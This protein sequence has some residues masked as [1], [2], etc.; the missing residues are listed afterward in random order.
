[1]VMRGVHYSADSLLHLGE[2][3]RRASP[4]SWAV[5][6]IAAAWPELSQS[7]IEAWP[8]GQ[9]DNAL[10]ALRQQQFGT[11]WLSEPVCSA[12]NATFEVGFD[13]LAMGFAIPLEWQPD[14]LPT[15]E[16]DFGAVTISLRPL[17]VHDLLAIERCS[18]EAGAKTYLK[19]ALGVDDEHFEKALEV[20]FDLDPLANIWI[21]TRCPECDAGQSLLFDPA[22]FLAEEMARSSDR[23]LGEVADLAFA[24]HWAEADILALPPARRAFY[25]SRIAA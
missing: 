15:R 4:A 8:L 23:L 14:A 22:R 18:S 17:M 13:P 20:A 5:Q 21:A 6:V 2:Y 1:M 19:N 12:C 3:A 11:E 16:C 25:L 10:V 9:M 7:R 24:Y